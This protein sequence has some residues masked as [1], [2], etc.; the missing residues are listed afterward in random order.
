MTKICTGG[1]VGAGDEHVPLPS[2]RKSDDTLVKSI[3]REIYSDET[4]EETKMQRQ[5]FTSCRLP[6]GALKI[7]T[8]PFSAAS[9]SRLN[10]IPSCVYLDEREKK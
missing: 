9:H 4:F 5:F 1:S 2:R 7:A 8:R 6:R 3:G 10:R